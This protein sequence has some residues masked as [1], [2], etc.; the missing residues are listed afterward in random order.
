MPE[1]TLG[2]KHVPIIYEERRYHERSSAWVKVEKDQ[3]S[4]SR[5][6]Y[7][8]KTEAVFSFA[9]DHSFE[10]ALPPLSEESPKPEFRYA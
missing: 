9:T 4:E 10:G 3:P 8:K 6:M 7:E 2:K 5:T 1:L